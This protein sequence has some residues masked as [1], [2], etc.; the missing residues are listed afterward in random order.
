M[1]LDP[2]WGDFYGARAVGSAPVPF[3]EAF[4]LTLWVQPPSFTTEPEVYDRNLKYGDMTVLCHVPN[5]ISVQINHFQYLFLLRVA[6]AV[7]EVSTLIFVFN[8]IYLKIIFI[9]CTFSL[10]HILLLINIT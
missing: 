7:D 1:R 8:I 10:L 6:D 5:L 3:L 9:M 2:V 4:P